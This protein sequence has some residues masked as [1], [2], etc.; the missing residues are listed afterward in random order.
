MT[1]KR[2]QRDI[3]R[4]SRDLRNLL[5]SPP[6]RPSVRP[7]EQAGKQAGTRLRSSGIATAFCLATFGFA[8]LGIQAVP[9]VVAAPPEDLG[10]LEPRPSGQ[11][12]LARFYRESASK[13]VYVTGINVQP[14]KKS[15]EEFFK[16]AENTHEEQTVGTGFLIHE[17]GYVVTNAH[18]VNRT[19]RP[20]VELRDGRRF[21]AEIMAITPKQD[22]ALL[23][24]TVPEKLPWAAV[25]PV[26][27]TSVGDSI[28]TIGSPHALKYTLSYGIVSA[29]GRSSMVTDIP[30]LV[31]H[32][33]LQTDA[34]INPGN[35]GGPWFNPYGRVVGVT[36][37]K[38]GDSDN[39]AFGISLETIHSEFPPMLHRAARKQW[40]L[41]FRATENLRA[42]SFRARLTAL[43]PEFSSRHDVHE[44]DLVVA[45]NDEPVFNG[46]DF[47]L[48]LLSCRAG[49]NLTL[50]LVRSDDL[51][52]YEQ[53][54]AV[55]LPSQS[56]SLP[57]AADSPTDQTPDSRQWTLNS[58][59]SRRITFTLSP[60]DAGDPAP[61]IQSRLR[62]RVKPLTESDVAEFNLRVPAGLLI[63]ELDE[64]M[65]QNLQHT[66]RRGDVLARLNCERPDSPESLAE[67][68]ENTPPD[69]P[70]DL[71]ILR[72]ETI[73]Q[74]TTF[75]RID[76]NNWK[77]R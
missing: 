15:T 73:D 67:I 52:S 48:K 6:A 2:R 59:A 72:R 1:H 74:K 17:D 61:L 42:Q 28:I 19:L 21:P 11:S 76:L 64:S 40:N 54:R 34:P 50:T 3:F 30:G 18:S 45:L 66:P 70:L 41:P 8:T 39:I 13:V 53:S 68:L 60:R 51:A 37:A 5:A 23:K 9:S 4:L 36:V 12:F 56:V 29:K 47:Y 27:E 46:I 32:G 25:E 7:P 49:D 16:P 62:M 43:D 75:T 35:S 20:E 63:E 58:P 31:L 26:P 44:G 65:F 22:L 55:A 77:A 69:A 57:Q 33:L 38:R 24:I 10:I 71:V 14:T